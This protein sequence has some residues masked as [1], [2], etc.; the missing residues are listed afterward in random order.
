MQQS[1]IILLLS[2]ILLTFITSCGS[3]DAE[4]IN[5]NVTIEDQFINLPSN[6]S[7]FFR[8][9]DGAGNGVAGL[10]EDDFLIYENGSVIS[11]FE[12]TRKI[13]PNEQVFDYHI[14]LMLDLSGS[15]LGSENLAGL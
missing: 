4:S 15:V 12:A 2:V 7:V 9:E 11:E 3:D 8:V 13:Q 10:N 14:T 6:V 1:K 5:L